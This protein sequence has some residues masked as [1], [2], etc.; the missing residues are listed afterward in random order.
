[1]RR[2]SDR[3]SIPAVC[4]DDEGAHEA[5]RVASEARHFA[6]GLAWARDARYEASSVLA[7][8]CLARELCDAGAPLELAAGALRAADDEVRHAWLC[9]ALATRYLGRR[10]VPVFPSAE[11]R[12]RLAGRAALV[13]LVIE[14]YVD[15]CIGELGAARIADL[16]TRQ[17]VDPPARLAQSLIARDERRHAE[18]A[19]RIVGW[20]LACG[21]RAVRTALAAELAR[22][23]VIEPSGVNAPELGRASPDEQWVGFS[24][25]RVEARTR[26]AR[27]LAA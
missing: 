5:V 25:A 13:R 6:A 8:V 17:A 19:F 9:A 18:L 26:I 15:G 4:L 24:E 12:P 2:G 27:M 16:A 10:V 11:L 7:F 20:A 1:L 23:R 22:A 14:S 3:V 21:D